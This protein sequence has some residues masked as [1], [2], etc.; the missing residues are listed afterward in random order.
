MS[1]EKDFK[2]EDIVMVPT[3]CEDCGEMNSAPTFRQ[4]LSNDDHPIV[5]MLDKNNYVD[6]LCQSCASKK[7]DSLEEN[8]DA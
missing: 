3:R 2:L 5:Q 7:V 1:K 6:I 8:N 4:Y